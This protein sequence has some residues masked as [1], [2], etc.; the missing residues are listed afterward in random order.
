MIRNA[1]LPE[2]WPLLQW[3]LGGVLVLGLLW[4]VFFRGS[5]QPPQVLGGGEA[6]PAALPSTTT[7]PPATSTTP[8]TTTGPGGTSAPVPTGGEVLLPGP[9]GD[10]AVPAEAVARVESVLRAAGGPDATFASR[11]VLESSPDRVVLVVEWY[12]NG[13]GVSSLITTEVTVNRGAGGLWEVG[14]GHR[15]A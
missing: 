6:P 14:S 8:T 15:G 2:W 12:P 3:V 13:P 5:D 9:A 10:V 11:E 1:Q 7:T 4:G